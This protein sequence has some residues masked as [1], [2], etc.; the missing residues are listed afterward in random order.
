MET[1]SEVSLFPIS[2]INFRW[3][4]HRCATED[5]EA[6]EA[7]IIASRIDFLG[8]S[9][10]LLGHWRY[11]RESNWSVTRESLSKTASW[12]IQGLLKTLESLIGTSCHPFPWDYGRNRPIKWRLSN[13]RSKSPLL[14]SRKASF[15]KRIVCFWRFPK[16]VR[17]FESEGPEFS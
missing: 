7:G 10:P 2:E 17:F 6:D 11:M 4:N 16:N 9:C 5:S 12:R 3:W 14:E 8:A 13:E 1:E 15:M